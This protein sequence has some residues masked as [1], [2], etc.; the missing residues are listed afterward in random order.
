M[1]SEAVFRYEIQESGDE[2]S[3]FV[4][5]ITCHGRLVNETSNEVKN[6]VKPLIM[7][8]GKIVLDFADLNYL[9]SSGLGALVG[10]KVSAIKEGYC[11]LELENLSPRLKELLRLS[12]LTQ[13]FSS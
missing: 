13:L 2:H 3:G 9:D 6:L 8:G 4:T 7:R 1:T 12:S 10:L 11:K 5:R